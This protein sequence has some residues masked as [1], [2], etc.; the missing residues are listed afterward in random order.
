MLDLIDLHSDVG[1]GEL[2]VKRKSVGF[3]NIAPFGMLGEDT[4]FAACEGL[5]RPLEVRAFEACRFA[6]EELKK[7]V[8]IWKK[9]YFEG[10]EVWIGSQSAHPQ[11]PENKSAT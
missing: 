8:P 2:P 1:M 4:R 6:I 11:Q 3:V 5:E 9:E 7:S 10:G